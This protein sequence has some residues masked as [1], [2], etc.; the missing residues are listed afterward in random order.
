MARRK[1]SGNS[2]VHSIENELE[3]IAADV[4]SLSSTIGDV[5]SAEARQMM[6][7]IRQRLDKIA[8]DAGYA[9]S[10]GVGTVRE[11]IRERPL[12]CVA[13]GAV[14]GFAVGFGIRR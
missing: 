4:A 8:D 7:S 3:A 5:A 11:T 13:V 2:R 14:L 10:A 6:E 9:T 12:T 1:K